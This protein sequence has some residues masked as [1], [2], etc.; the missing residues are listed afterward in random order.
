M[1]DFSLTGESEDSNFDLDNLDSSSSE[2]I[3]PT[4]DLTLPNGEDLGVDLT[5]NT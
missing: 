5:Q 3:E 2:I 4:S 1:D